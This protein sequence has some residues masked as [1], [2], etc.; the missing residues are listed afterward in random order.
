MEH[1][2]RESYRVLKK[3][4]VL[5]A[6]FSNPMVYL[7]EDF[8]IHDEVRLR[9]KTLGRCGGFIISPSH[10]IQPDVPIENILAFYDAVKKFGVYPI[11]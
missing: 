9:I 6:G 7:F 5:L 4:G 11:D 8:D 10:S 2:W 1:V 3:G